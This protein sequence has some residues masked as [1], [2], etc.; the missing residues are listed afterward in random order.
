[1]IELFEANTLV[2]NPEKT[3]IMKFILSNSPHSALTI[4]YKGKDIEETVNSKFFGSHL[5][6]HLNWNDHTDQMIP[7]LIIMYYFLTNF[8]G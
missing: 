1:M 2:L 5:D 7:K 8:K 4:D 6:N 3:N